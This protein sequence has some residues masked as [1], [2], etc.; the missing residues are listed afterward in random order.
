MTKTEKSVSDE[1]FRQNIVDIQNRQ[2]AEKEAE[3]S[4]SLDEHG[5]ADDLNDEDV[6]EEED[7]AEVSLKD[8]LASQELG[9]LEKICRDIETQLEGPAATRK[10]AN[11][12]VKAI[13]SEAETHGMNREA[14]KLAHKFLKWDNTKRDSFI[15]SFQVFLSA[16][17]YNMQQD[18]FYTEEYLQGCE[19]KSASSK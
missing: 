11:E 5:E 19:S 18:L 13:L 9:E 15:A 3:A 16:H 17:G 12:Q 10:R 8:V 7:T 4:G 1:E 14:V 2:K 6:E